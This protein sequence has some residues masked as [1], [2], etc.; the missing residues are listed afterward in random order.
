[1]DVEV[2]KHG[3]GHKQF[4]QVQAAQARNTLRPACLVYLWRGTDYMVAGGYEGWLLHSPGL[5]L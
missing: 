2:R 5:A 3:R 4:T 1:M